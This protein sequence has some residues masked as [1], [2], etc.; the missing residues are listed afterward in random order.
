[1]EQDP[2]IRQALMGDVESEEDEA[3]V[4][5][6]SKGD[7]SADRPD[8]NSDGEGDHECSCEGCDIP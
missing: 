2:D 3:L 7:D 5:T 8:G 6:D 4:D 1:M